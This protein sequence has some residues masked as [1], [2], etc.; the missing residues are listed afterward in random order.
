MRTLIQNILLTPGATGE[1]HLSFIPD[2][3]I[4]I[5]GPIIV[6][7][8]RADGAPPFDKVTPTKR[9]TLPFDHGLHDQHIIVDLQAFRHPSPVDPRSCEPVAPCRG[10]AEG[11]FQMN[12]LVGK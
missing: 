9:H 4:Q 8:G 3:L 2:A 12:Q 10:R 6:Y 1:K 5:D 7:A 11:L